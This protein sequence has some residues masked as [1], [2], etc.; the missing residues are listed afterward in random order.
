MPPPL[1]KLGCGLGWTCA[2]RVH[3]VTVAVDLYLQQLCRTFKTV[4]V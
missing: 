2:S 3:A 1:F 4:S